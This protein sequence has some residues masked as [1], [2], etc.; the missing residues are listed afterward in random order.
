MKLIEIIDSAPLLPELVL[1]A[2]RRGKQ[3][4]LDVERTTDTPHRLMSAYGSIFGVDIEDDAVKF[5]YYAQGEHD[6]PALFFVPLDA[7]DDILNIQP[8]AHGD[9]EIVNATR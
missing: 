5:S 8:A 1:Q 9:L 2:L 3:V 4:W 7:I 6:T